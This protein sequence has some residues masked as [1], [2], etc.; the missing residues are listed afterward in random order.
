MGVGRRGDES[1]LE[2]GM[3][4]G[5][6]VVGRGGNSAMEEVEGKVENGKEGVEEVEGVEKVEGMGA[7][8]KAEVEVE[9]AGAGWKDEVAEKE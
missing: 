9:E 7:S 3:D 1:R 5:R 8:D 4:G 2:R 6:G